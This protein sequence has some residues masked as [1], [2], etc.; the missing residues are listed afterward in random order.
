MG[1]QTEHE[2]APNK[3]QGRVILKKKL[4]GNIFFLRWQTTAQKTRRAQLCP[5]PRLLPQR[6]PAAPQLP[7]PLLTSP[8]SEQL[9][10]K[11][12]NP[13]VTTVTYVGARNFLFLQQ[14]KP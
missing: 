5:A 4:I 6:P 9:F 13:N 12:K 11:K 2:A 1:L 7:P 14:S 10:S 3:V 8:R